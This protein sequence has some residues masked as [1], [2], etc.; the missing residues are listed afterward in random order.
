MRKHLF[1]LSLLCIIALNSIAGE[2][3]MNIN[4]SKDWNYLKP[5]KKTKK[6][7]ISKIHKMN[8]QKVDLPHFFEDNAKGYGWYH[9]TIIIPEK[10]PKNKIPALVFGQADDYAQ[11]YI[12]GKSVKENFVWNM[13]FYIELTPWLKEGNHN[14]DIA[15]KVRN[16]GGEG[17]LLK[18]VELRCTNNIDEIYKTELYGQEIALPLEKLGDMVIYSVYVR[19]FTPE[20]TFQAM[21]KRIPELENLGVNTL[22][23]LPIHPIGHEKRKGI[24]G[25]PYAIQDYYGIAPELGTKKDFKSLV[26]T[27]HKHNMKLIID[28]VLNHTSP[29][30]VIA[31]QHPEWFLQDEN[32]KPRPDN[33]GWADIVDFDW[34]NKEVWTYC[35][36]M[37]E[38]WVRELD[39]DGYRCDVAD[40]MPE[41]FWKETREALDKIKPG[42]IR[43]LAESTS[44]TKHISG[45]DITYHEPLYETIKTVLEDKQAADSIRKLIIQNQYSFP[46]SASRL[47]FI[48]NHDKPRAI[49]FYGGPEE[50]KLAAVLTATLPGIPLL[51]T[52]TEIG[53][54][55]NR[56]KT[57]FKKSTV[58][59]TK[60]LHGM[61]AFWASLLALRK[62]HPALQKGTIRFL[63][64]TQNEHVLA[65]ERTFDDDT[66][67]IMLNFSKKAQTFKV[68]HPAFSHPLTLGGRMWSI[69]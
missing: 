56:D 51:Y 63:K 2:A 41:P 28:C 57:F 27:A 22:W 21:E 59:F 37:M 25:S 32:G 45:F 19:N 38:Y 68:D 34:E 8:T 53:C 4:F 64:T 43:M 36:E 31:K 40:L 42:E 47:L 44:A 54:D 65:Y 46:K 11:V 35:R 61:R 3:A 50:T 13:P 24:D 7:S 39:I 48:E 18:K 49:N 66:V 29:D 14:L 58:D 62:S 60:D 26:D 16:D 23:L 20:G 5:D 9:K 10:L 17:G 12:N 67:I 52:G 15:V 69:H 6:L 1:Y 55:A 33:N 30:S